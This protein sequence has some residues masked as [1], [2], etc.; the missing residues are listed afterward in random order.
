MSAA[1]AD[2][3]SRPQMTDVGWHDYVMSH[4]APDEL[5][6]GVPNVKG[7]R[8]VARLLLGPPSQSVSRVV[9]FPLYDPSCKEIGGWQPAVAEHTLAFLWQQPD[10]LQGQYVVFSDCACVWADNCLEANIFRFMVEVAA[11]KAESRAYK[12]ALQLKCLTADEVVPP[13]PQREAVPATTRP[14][15][16]SQIVFMDAK[17]RQL[18]IGLMAFVNSGRH[19]Y[20]SIRDVSFDSARAMN[21]ALSDYQNDP[22]TIPANLRGGYR[23]DWRKS[24]DR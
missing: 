4:F 3:E 10:E 1:Q 17:C 20:K 16:D 13:A 15:E 14:I 6:N 22:K 12:R 2:E 23:A 21:E 9:Q 5:Q 18:G 19:R 7:L 24:F 8:R 11:T